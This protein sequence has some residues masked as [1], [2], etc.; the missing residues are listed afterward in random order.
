MEFRALPEDIELE[1]KTAFGR[2]AFATRT[3]NLKLIE[4][5]I[6]DI[7]ECYIQQPL[8]SLE[9]PGK[10]TVNFKYKSLLK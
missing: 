3:E 9:T 1:R 8:V 5:I 6:K 2:I 10:A 7:D 4:N